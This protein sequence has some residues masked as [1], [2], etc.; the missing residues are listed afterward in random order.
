M[1]E[2][3]VLVG[4][5]MGKALRVWRRLLAGPTGGRW[6]YKRAA[7]RGLV[8]AA[9]ALAL[10]LLPIALAFLAVPVSA[11]WLLALWAFS[12]I[13][14]VRAWWLLRATVVTPDGVT[15]LGRGTRHVATAVVARSLWWTWCAT[16]AFLVSM[17][18]FGPAAVVEFLDALDRVLLIPTASAG[19]RALPAVLALAGAAVTGG[20][21]GLSVVASMAGPRRCSASGQRVRDF[22]GGCVACVEL[23]VLLLLVTL[24]AMATPSGW[25]L[26]AALWAAA[27]LG[28]V[29]CAFALMVTVRG[30]VKMLTPG[31]DG[32]GDGDDSAG[33]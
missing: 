13:P 24:A 15:L 33:T 5:V 10:L 8:A 28:A 25:P 9:I 31:H 3:A 19:T 21:V 17:I 20:L 16:A 2:L 18:G 12:P 11:W 7:S 1:R 32:D 14:Q 6:T 30:L 4:R 29:A 27:L 26:R 23:A 22:A